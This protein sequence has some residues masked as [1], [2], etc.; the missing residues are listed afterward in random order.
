MGM[1]NAKRGFTEQDIRRIIENQRFL[2]RK[3]GDKSS[4]LIHEALKTLRWAFSQLPQ[5]ITR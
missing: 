5:E 2:I 3:Y 4:N 1:R